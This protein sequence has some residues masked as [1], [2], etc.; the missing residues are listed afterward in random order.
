MADMNYI[1][2]IVKILENPVQKVFNKTITV[3]KFRVQ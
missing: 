3:T 1:S 2:G